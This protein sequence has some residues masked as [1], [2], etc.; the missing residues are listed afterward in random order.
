MLSVRLVSI[1]SKVSLTNF[2]NNLSPI[3]VGYLMIYNLKLHKKFTKK[4]VSCKRFPTEN[5]HSV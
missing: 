4:Q 2:S 3:I 5:M 1:V